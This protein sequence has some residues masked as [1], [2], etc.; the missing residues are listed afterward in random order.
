MVPA[1]QHRRGIAAA[2]LRDAVDEPIRRGCLQADAVDPAEHDARVALL[3]HDGAGLERPDA[4]AAREVDLA[5][6]AEH[7]Q[8]GRRIERE[9]GCPGS[10]QYIRKPPLTL[11]VAPEM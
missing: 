4:R 5:D 10:H 11:I 3:E 7:R 9:G 8:S 1:Q 2:C 6:E